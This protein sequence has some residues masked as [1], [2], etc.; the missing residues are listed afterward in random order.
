MKIRE[1][2]KTFI[3]CT[4]KYKEDAH[5]LHFSKGRKRVIANIKGGRGGKRKKKWA[6]SFSFRS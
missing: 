1:G 6:R 5:R 3:R 4:E 2:E